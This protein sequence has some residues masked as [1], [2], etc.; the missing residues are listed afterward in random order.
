MRHSAI[1]RSTSKRLQ[2][3]TAFLLSVAMVAGFLP[4]NAV[5]VFADGDQPEVQYKR[6]TVEIEDLDNGGNYNTQ[7][8]IEYQAVPGDESS[9]TE[10]QEVDESSMYSFPDTAITTIT[11]KDDEGNEITVNVINTRFTF[12]RAEG[13]PRV[14]TGFKACIGNE[15]EVPVVD[16]FLDES[17]CTAKIP[18]PVDKGVDKVIFRIS[19]LDNIEFTQ[20]NGYKDNEF[21]LGNFYQFRIDR[22]ID[23]LT[24]PENKMLEI[25]GADVSINTLTLSKGSRLQIMDNNEDYPENSAK[26]GTLTVTNIVGAEDA[27]ILFKSQAN[28]P[29][30]F[31]FYRQTDSGLVKVTNEDLNNNDDFDWNWF[32]LFYDVESKEWILMEPIDYPLDIE[33]DFL[34]DDGNDYSTTLKVMCQTDP[35]NTNSWDEIKPEAGTTKYMLPGTAIDG[36]GEI[37]L[38]IFL[39]KEEGEGDPRV[40]TGITATAG[41]KQIIPVVDE[42]LNDDLD[43]LTIPFSV[44]DEI[45]NLEIRVS[46]INNIEFTQENEWNQGNFFYQFRIGR[47][48]DSLTVPSGKMLEIYGADVSITTLTLSEDSRLQ[49]MDN[50]DDKTNVITGSFSVGNILGAKDATILFQSADYIPDGLKIYRWTGEEHPVLIED[51]YLDDEEWFNVFYDEGEGVWILDEGDPYEVRIVISD[52]S[53]LIG[54]TL[55]YNVEY[56]LAGQDWVNADIEG[57]YPVDFYP[58]NI[59]GNTVIIDQNQRDLKV[60]NFRLPDNPEVFI[61]DPIGSDNWVYPQVSFKITIEDIGDIELLDASIEMGEG[62]IDLT[63]TPDG[64]D[65]VLTASDLD[66]DAISHDIVLTLDGGFNTDD[67]YGL[68][69]QIPLDEDSKVTLSENGKSA[70]LTSVRNNTLTVTSESKIFVENVPGG[71]NQ[72]TLTNLWSESDKFYLT[73]VTQD[74]STAYIYNITEEGSRDSL[75]SEEPFTVTCDTKGAPV[76]ADVNFEAPRLGFNGYESISPAPGTGNWEGALTASSYDIVYEN[77][78]V[79]VELLGTDSTWKGILEHRFDEHDNDYIDEFRIET[80]AQVKVTFTPDEGFEVDP[81][82]LEN[83]NLGDDNSCTIYLSTEINYI[84]NPFRE[85]GGNPPDPQGTCKAVFTGATGM[86]DENTEDAIVV[87]NYAHGSVTLTQGEGTMGDGDVFNPVWDSETNTITIEYNRTVEFTI[88]A[89]EDY[90]STCKINNV[91]QGY[92]DAYSFDAIP[93]TTVDITFTGPSFILEVGGNLKEGTTYEVDNTNNKITL[94]YDHGTVEITNYISLVEKNGVTPDGS[95]VVISY[96]FT[97]EGNSADVTFIPDENYIF[98]GMHLDGKDVAPD[99]ERIENGVLSLTGIDKNNKVSIEPRFDETPVLKIAAV[100]NDS[101]TYNSLNKT[102]TFSEDQTDKG[103]VEITN[104]SDPFSGN[105]QNY[106][107]ITSDITFTITPADRY[108]CFV[109]LNNGQELYFP[110]ADTY[111]LKASDL[112]SDSVEGNENVLT[113]E[114]K[115]LE[116]DQLAKVKFDGEVGSSG[117][118]YYVSYIDAVAGIE[119]GNVKISKD[120]IESCDEETSTFTIKQNVSSL[121]LT[122]TPKTG[123]TPKLVEYGPEYGDDQTVTGEW[124][125]ELTLTNNNGTYSYTLAINPQNG[126]PV[127]LRVSFDNTKYIQTTVTYKDYEGVQCA[128]EIGGNGIPGGDLNKKLVEYETP[129]SLD[130]N[131]NSKEYVKVEDGKEYVRMQFS[132]PFTYYMSEVK[133]NGNDYSTDLPAGYDELIAA[134]GNQYTNAVIWVEI[135]DSYVIE[136][137]VYKAVFDED[138]TKTTLAVGNFLWCYDRSKMDC[139]DDEYVEN[140]YLEIVQVV[141]DGNVYTK[142]NITQGSAI[143]WA[144]IEK[145]NKIVGGQATLPAGSY[146]TMKF[147]PDYGTQLVS[148]GLNGNGNFTVDQGQM[149]TY[150]FYVGPGNFHL[151][152]VFEEVENVVDNSS[153]AV[154]SGSVAIGDDEITNGTAVL[155]VGDA[156][157]EGDEK[158]SFENV[159]VEASVQITSY[160]DISLSQVVYQGVSKNEVS[161]SGDDKNVWSEGLNNLS[162][163]ATITL[164]L[165]EEPE[166]DEVVVLHYHDGEVDILDADYDAD[167]NS[168]TFDTDSFSDYAVAYLVDSYDLW[169]GGIQVTS[170]N[171]SNVLGDTGTPTVVYDADT[172]TL[173]LNGATIT[174]PD[175]VVL[176]WNAG[177]GIVYSGTEDFTIKVTGGVSTVTGGNTNRDRSAGLLIADPRYVF[178]GSSIPCKTTIIID[179]GASLTLVG[180]VPNTYSACSVGLLCDTNGGLTITGSGT[181]NAAG[182]GG[183]KIGVSE[184]IYTSKQLTIDG[185][186]VNVSGAANSSVSV[187]VNAGI[188]S[189]GG[190]I[191]NSGTV[192]T[193]AG[194]IDDYR[195]WSYGIMNTNNAI[196]INGGTLT[197]SGYSSAL[198]TAPTLG[199]GVTAS[200]STNIDGSDAVPYSAADN[201]SCLWFNTSYTPPTYGISLDKTGTYTFTEATVGYSALTPVTVTV[202]NTGTGSTGNLTV[203]L[204]NGSFTLSKTYLSGIAPGGSATF[205]IVPRTGLPPATYAGIV[206]VSGENNISA[207]FNVS[208]KVN[209]VKY[210]VTINGGITDKET[211][212]AGETVTILATQIPEGKV[213]DK[214]VA[215]SDDVVFYNASAEETIFTMPASD[216]EITATYKDVKYTVTFNTN[217]HGTAPAAQTVTYGSKATQPAALTATGYTFGGWYTDKACTKAYDFSTA[218]KA[219]ITLYAKWTPV[220]YTVTFNANGH[221]TAPA[222][223][224]VTYGGKATQPAAP[225]ATG[226]T[227]GGWYTDAACT[228]AYSFS[229]AVTANITLYAKWTAV[230]TPSPTPTV[231]PS[232]TLL[233]GGGMAHVQDFGDTPVSVD[234][235]TGILTIG[236][237]GMGKRLEE[238]TINFTN[239]TPYAGTLQYRVH[240]QD[241]GW[242]DWV[243]AGQPA[244]T[245]GL[246]KRIE[247][248]ELRLTGELAQYYSVEYC[249]HIEDYGDMQGWVKDGALAGTTGESKRIEQI[250]IRIVPKGTGETISVKYRVHVQDYGWEKTYATNGAMSGTSGESK[251]LE[252][253]EIFLSGTQYSGGI[254]F[255]THVQDYG[256]QDWSYDGEMSGTQGESKRL[257][258]IC[259]ELYGEVAK[260]YDIYY[261]VHA[262]DIG[263]MGWAKNGE[264]AGTAGRSA[265]LEGIQIVL[266]PKGSPAPGATYDG[267]TAVDSRAFVEG[268]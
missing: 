75:S 161:Y 255:K 97:L 188:Y 258:G 226:F 74:G 212:A 100:E 12:E 223:Q 103:T 213:F 9:W 250:K 19:N 256:W 222:A 54:T 20:N 155:F 228:K 168:I 35:N 200:G 236:T 21:N 7:W 179:E 40:I 130:A 209:P 244:G 190:V 203:A 165:A 112:R 39:V 167:T 239:T 111:T 50:S 266:V 231:V 8:K 117:D 33:V 261:R 96:E 92:K 98:N 16:E 116:E 211:A 127:G 268:F 216:V 58:D 204:S 69:V 101:F 257:E 152:A 260:Y 159:A 249:V 83:W 163:P 214:W 219:N 125:R 25:F 215:D 10:A 1:S 15:T 251:R 32:N 36:N 64:D 136:T 102:L 110:V 57:R 30:G 174:G 56:K 227:F 146:V 198:N 166:S 120:A 225:S 144:D 245:E 210:A 176:G 164:E 137:K 207:T 91:D 252:G 229:T 135:A 202:T 41:N 259:I 248:I 118:Y 6:V 192:T 196:T 126:E 109:K 55:T 175:S 38:N 5:K 47:Q 172:N 206:T 224:T 246:S 2:R 13:D 24:I 194:Y 45:S 89:D 79:T 95:S 177:G 169:V 124:T 22:K 66:F 68:S 138:P 106:S 123:Y 80:L 37:L 208:F 71:E 220:N 197:A 94:T 42:L 153:A 67:Y 81:W 88:D 121:E 105:P 263:W 26:T 143:S 145:D 267:I 113:F 72:P 254:K 162:N 134:F 265:R 232:S 217:G 234:P 205:T 82:I 181:L 107:E 73:A 139:Q 129:L 133:I 29:N 149:Y 253:I 142:D 104:E 49:V 140:A 77:G 51:D 189:C 11:E 90:D 218:V 221:G 108:V 199:E 93:E 147:I 3:L 186:T 201:D 27:T 243:N 59:N 242:M 156:A 191:I 241:I 160:L 240:V 65:L 119:L 114:F 171:A 46:N 178:S 28:I 17:L 151:N 158:T 185:P 264:C 63:Q 170:A 84:N 148:L 115:K 180:G 247:A 86:T 233:A 18:F 62:K 60:I 85:E 182:S 238:I 262:Q 61:E 99:D 23:S 128:I 122:I 187:I 131:E 34:D 4:L 78:K 193:T 70:I 150:S 235:T 237:T 14:I 31:E 183:G 53:N 43:T 157:P 184:G 76:L 230:P 195:D 52:D 44:D 154:S 132:V 87:I 48:L 141:Y 173:T